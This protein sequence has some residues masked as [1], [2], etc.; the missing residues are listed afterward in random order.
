M[1]FYGLSLEFI[2]CWFFKNIFIWEK[3]RNSHLLIHTWNARHRQRWSKLQSGTGHPILLSHTSHGWWAAMSFNVAL[4]L[5][6]AHMH[7]RLDSGAQLS[8]QLDTPQ[9]NTGV[10]RFK[11]CSKDCS[12]PTNKSVHLPIF[13]FISEFCLPSLIGSDLWLQ[14]DLRMLLLGACTW[15]KEV[16]PAMCPSSLDFSTINCSYHITCRSFLRIDS[17]AQ[18]TG[19]M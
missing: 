13:L 12:A 11:S 9:W 5:P 3:E 10:C 15:N 7:K 6:K 4:L 2:K 16:L 14:E 19:L 1:I 18:D 17:V 8:W